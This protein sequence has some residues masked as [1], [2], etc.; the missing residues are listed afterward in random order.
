MISW[1][2]GM[3][4]L[5]ELAEK[6]GYAPK[7]GAAVVSVQRTEVLSSSAVKKAMRVGLSDRNCLA[8]G[9][10]WSYQYDEVSQ[11]LSRCHIEKEEAW[12]DEF[13]GTLSQ[14]VFDKNDRVRAV[15]LCSGI[16]DG[17]LVDLLLGTANA[18]EYLMTALQAFIRAA[19]GYKTEGED[20]ICMVVSQEMVLKLLRR[21]L[22]KKYEIV[23]IGRAHFLEEE[24][25]TEFLG[26][27]EEAGAKAPL[28]ENISWK[29]PWAKTFKSTGSKGEDA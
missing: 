14:I 26:A 27:M 2:S 28:Q 4:D 5:D 10:L 8:L 20:R 9:E 29:I 25:D 18:S 21:V 19:G 16:S 22:D 3:K 15:I 1:Y 6:K 7:E 23:E 12:L 24:A 11:F 13:D 17:I